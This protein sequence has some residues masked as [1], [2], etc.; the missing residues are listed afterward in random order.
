MNQ[1]LGAALAELSAA[2]GYKKEYR[3]ELSEEED[4]T[5]PQ[6]RIGASGAL[7]NSLILSRESQGL[8]ISQLIFDFGRTANLAA[9]AQFDALSQAQKAQLVFSMGLSPFLT[10]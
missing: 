2:L 6:I 3:F 4:H 5:V 1:P 7:N 10:S 9:A 8:N